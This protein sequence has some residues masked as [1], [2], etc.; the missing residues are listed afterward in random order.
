MTG[1][2]DEIRPDARETMQVLQE[3]CIDVKMITGD[4]RITSVNVGRF[5]MMVSPEEAQL[6]ILRKSEILQKSVLR[7]AEG[8]KEES[9]SAD[10]FKL[11]SNL[12][13]S[14]HIINTTDQVKSPRDKDPINK[15]LQ[16]NI[17]S[18]IMTANP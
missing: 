16:D 8:S 4:A 2:R 18:I 14:Q 6:E 10:P 5:L 12:Y 15:L 9:E 11:G 17:N 3:A 7:H 1:L 13:Q